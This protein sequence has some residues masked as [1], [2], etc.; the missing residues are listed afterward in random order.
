MQH[1]FRYKDLSYRKHIHNPLLPRS[2]S[3]TQEVRQAQSL[4]CLLH[5]FVMVLDPLWAVLDI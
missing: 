3:N 1:P 2:S 5:S 4:G